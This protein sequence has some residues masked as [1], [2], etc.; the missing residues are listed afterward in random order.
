M[1]HAMKSSVYA[2]S[3]SGGTTLRADEVIGRIVPCNRR[4]PKLSVF[5][6]LLERS[7]VG[8]A[9]AAQ[10][11]VVDAEEA[12]LDVDR[13]QDGGLALDRGEGSRATTIVLAKG[14]DA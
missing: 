11:E 4:A 12:D 8:D 1:P 14:R 10:D 6:A 9:V 3:R 7:A 5:D 2:A 13:G